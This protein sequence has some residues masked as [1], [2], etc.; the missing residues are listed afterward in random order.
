MK[1]KDRH[2]AYLTRT[3]RALTHRTGKSVSKRDVMEAILDLCIRDE[4]QF[5]P[6]DFSQPLSATRREVVQ[7]Q[8]SA[9]TVRLEPYELLEALHAS[10]PSEPDARRGR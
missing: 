7:A 10:A 2:E 9:R 4:E 5:D 6:E 3:A 8:R 1:L